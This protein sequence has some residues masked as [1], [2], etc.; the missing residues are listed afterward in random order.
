MHVEVKFFA[1]I[2]EETGT[3]ATRREF[4]DGA[5]V[6]DVLDAVRETYPALDLLDADGDVHGHLNV[7]RN[8]RNVYYLDGLDTPLEDGDTVSIFSPVSG[9]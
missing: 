1:R 3:D 2:R 4:P 9:G 7:L 6:G 8:D 5:T